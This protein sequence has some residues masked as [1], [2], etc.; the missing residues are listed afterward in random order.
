MKTEKRKKLQ[1][2]LLQIENFLKPFFG[3]GLFHD[4]GQGQE[5]LGV[6]VIIKGY[7]YGHG[8]SSL[9]SNSKVPVSDWLSNLLYPTHHIT[10]QCLWYLGET[11]T[12]TDI[13]WVGDQPHIHQVSV[14]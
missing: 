12:V 1:L 8:Q 7:I 4:F 5:R 14:V 11:V 10:V 3:E 2:W 6:M 13:S 9:L